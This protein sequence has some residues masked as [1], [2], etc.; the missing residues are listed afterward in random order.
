[1][2]KHKNDILLSSPNKGTILPSRFFYTILPLSKFRRSGNTSIFKASF[3]GLLGAVITPR[4]F[5]SFQTV[6]IC[7]SKMNCISATGTGY[8]VHLLVVLEGMIYAL[9]IGTNK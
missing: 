2:T 1:M 5:S 7:T 4:I 8:H 3:G 6:Q 9:I